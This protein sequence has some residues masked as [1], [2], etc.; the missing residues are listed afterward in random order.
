[1][2]PQNI[3]TGIYTDTNGKRWMS[4]DGLYLL[5]CNGTRVLTRSSCYSAPYRA[6]SSRGGS[7]CFVALLPATR[8]LRVFESINHQLS[9]FLVTKENMSKRNTLTQSTANEN[10]VQSWTGE[11]NWKPKNPARRK[12]NEKLIVKRDR[13]TRHHH[14]PTTKL[15]LSSDDGDD[16]RSGDG[17]VC[18]QL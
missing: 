7:R 14:A 2:F 11:K 5:E 8:V 15:C 9:L 17:L 18:T 13:T 6:P 16:G 3:L 4:H 12:R 1:V 10:S